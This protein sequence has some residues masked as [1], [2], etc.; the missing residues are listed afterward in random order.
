M[1][2]VPPKDAG[3]DQLTAQVRMGL[4][5]ADKGK[6]NPAMMLKTAR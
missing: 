5:G 2:L 1:L 6:S 4:V 3:S